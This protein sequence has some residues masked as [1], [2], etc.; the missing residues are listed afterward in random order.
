MKWKDVRLRNKFGIGFGSIMILF[1]FA[2]IWAIMGIGNIVDDARQVIEANKIK[3]KFE[4]ALSDHLEW[5]SQVSSFIN[6][7]DVTSLDVEVDPTKCNFG[8]W[9][10]SDQRRKAEEMIPELKSTLDKMESPHKTMHQAARKIKGV[11]IKVDPQLGQFLTQK[12]NDHLRWMQKVLAGVTDRDQTRIDVQTDYRQC[13]L[14]KWLYSKEVQDKLRK[15]RVFRGHI[16]PVF[17]PHKK[18]HS[19][20]KDINQALEQGHTDQAMRIYL[21]QT[22]KYAQEVLDLLQE[23]ATW[24]EGKMQKLQ[25]LRQVYTEEINPA[26]DQIQSHLHTT[27]E[28]VKANMMTDRKMLDAAAMTRTTMIV[29]GVVAVLIGI[30]LAFIIAR[31]ILRALQQGVN[32]ASTLAQGDLTQTLNIEQKDEIG[33][34]AQALNAMVHNLNSMIKNQ[35]TSI[36]TLASSSNELTTIAEQMSSTAESTVSKAN[37]VASAAEEMS[38]NM[39]SVAS[40]ME[41]ASSNVST[42]VSG[43]DEMSSNIESISQ[44]SEQAREVADSAASQARSASKRI[45]ELKDAAQAIGKVTEAITSI[46]SQTNLLAL[47]AT[48]EAA[49]AGEAGKGFAVVANEI[50]ELAQQTAD[51]TGDI[52]Q[53][54]EDIQN[55]TDVSVNEIQEVVQVINQVQEF[56]SSSATAMEEQ[57]ITT[58]DIASNISQLSQG[59]QEINE[60]VSQSSQASAQVAEDI[61]TVNESASEISNT[62][63]QVQTT[64][65]DLNELAERLK[66]AAAKFKV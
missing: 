65:K 33:Q 16:E 36:D 27:H 64:A 29:I 26:L 8:Q 42:V 1:C 56:V 39:N 24:Q 15:D 22:K 7:R 4:Q 46:S 25:E 2:V 47:N 13:G 17:D 34:L 32:F 52:A 50:K 30:V 21:Q 41:Q 63:A 61:N 58:K 37:T 6:D 57:S 9:F 48:I 28:I 19:S 38:T 62:S 14:G 23:A 20:V 11:E 55:S 60:N 3:G 59:I 66:Q 43:V 35:G 12:I 44:Q 49:R 31:G 53:K 45:N 51:A 40:S 5:A 18:L 10:Y 54:I